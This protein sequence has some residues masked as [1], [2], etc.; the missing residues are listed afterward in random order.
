MMEYNIS[1]SSNSLDEAHLLYLKVQITFQAN[2]YL[3]L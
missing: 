3:F 2:F 1:I